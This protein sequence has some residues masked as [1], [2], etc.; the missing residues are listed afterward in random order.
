MVASS[1]SPDL[2]VLDLGL[3]DIDGLEVLQR[4][5]AF[6]TMPV[7]VVTAHHQQSEKIRAL[8]AGADD[9]VTKPF[10]TEELLARIRATL[11]RVPQSN[12]TPTLVRIDGVEIDLA[13]RR[14]T[15]DGTPVHLT[16]TE[17]ALLELLVSHPGKLLTQ[18]FLLREVWGQG[19]GSESN[20]LPG[21]RGSA[22]QEARRRRRAPAP[23]PDRT[24]H[25]IPL[26]RRRGTPHLTRTSVEIMSTR[27]RRCPCHRPAHALGPRVVLAVP[28][29]P[30]AA[31]PPARRAVADARVGPLVLAV[32]ARR[33]DR[34]ARRLPRCAAR[35]RGDAGS[36]RE[37]GPARDRPVDGPHGRVHGVG[38]D[39]GARPAVRHRAGLR[40]RWRHGRRA[41]C[42]TC[43]ATSPRCR[44]CCASRLRARGRVARRSGG[45]RTDRVLV[46]SARRIA[47]ARRVS[48]RLLLQRSRHSRRRQASRRCGRATTS[49]N[50][51]T[52]AARHAD[53]ER[54]R[55][56]DA[57]TMAR[58]GRRRGERGTGRVRIRGDVVARVPRRPAVGP[59]SS[60]SP[61]SCDPAPAPT[62]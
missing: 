1:G 32:P 40:A 53:D 13:A 60:R 7:I 11:R 39:D 21:V 31:R 51:A 49:T 2:M 27:P 62:C 26:D 37:R 14:V 23:H 8:D 41:T 57:A 45:G 12:P 55:P 47:R 25:R 6:S 29:V 34:G 52:R 18:E 58:T 22:A 43:S 20:Y 42:P 3:P 36:P 10:D 17:L 54:H 5:R 16:R 56:S 4:V 48:L 15:L 50:W 35:G 44:S 28:D 59:G 24:R 19:Y 46:G 33:A 30:V 61:A 9:Y 38:R